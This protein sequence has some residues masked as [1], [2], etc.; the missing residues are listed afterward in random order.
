[1]TDRRYFYISMFC[2]VFTVATFVSVY[3]AATLFKPLI[4]SNP[5]SL[6]YWSRL[7]LTG[8]PILECP[9]APIFG[10]IF[11]AANNITG[12]YLHYFYMYAFFPFMGSLTILNLFFAS[13]FPGILYRRL[14]HNYKTYVSN[15]EIK[16]L[17]IVLAIGLIL[18]IFVTSIGFILFK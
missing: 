12:L 1:M 3:F 11:A 5:D 17:K 13:K 4:F 14:K 18:Q 15:G 6:C 8:S 9:N 16:F 2:F 10:L 7:P